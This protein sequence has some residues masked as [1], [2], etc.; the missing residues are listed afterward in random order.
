VL[1]WREFESGVGW[2]N[3]FVIAS[4]LSLARALSQSGAAA[5]LARALL[6]GTDPGTALGGASTNP[7]T[8]VVALLLASAA[9][10]FLVPNITGFLGVTIPVAMSLGANAGLNPLVCGL[11]VTIAGDAVL[12]YPA[13]SASSLV[14]YQRGHLTAGEILRFGVWM[15]VLAF[16][17]VLVVAIPYWGLVGEPLDQAR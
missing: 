2:T 3:L 6:P 11:V 5:W 8:I 9:I 14:V 12:Y 13:Q 4:S 1:E 15:T 16:V 7:L 10:R 17:V